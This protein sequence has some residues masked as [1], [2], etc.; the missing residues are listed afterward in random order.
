MRAAARAARDAGVRVCELAPEELTDEMR[1]KLQHDVSGGWRPWQQQQQQ[2]QQQHNPKFC[3]Q[4]KFQAFVSRCLV[5]SAVIV[6]DR[7][8]LGPT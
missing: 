5:G 4:E 2:Q 1:H 8:T 6:E 7:E 3:Q